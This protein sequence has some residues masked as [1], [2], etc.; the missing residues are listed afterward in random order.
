MGT[1][2]KIHLPASSSA[3]TDEV[4]PGVA[5]KPGGRGEVVLVVEDEPD[6]LRMAERILGRAGYSVIGD[7]RTA[8][9]RSRSASGTTSRSTCC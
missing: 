6:V 2:I 4:E 9:R 5:P 3:P 8:P 7:R 1:T